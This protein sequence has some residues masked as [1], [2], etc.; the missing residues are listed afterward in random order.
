M[1][2]YRYTLTIIIFT[3]MAIEDQIIYWG[4]H[5]YW[6]PWYGALVLGFAISYGIARIIEGS[7]IRDLRNC[8]K[9]KKNEL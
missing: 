1:M 2:K 7:L 4:G 5:L 3:A 9:G 8:R 6:F